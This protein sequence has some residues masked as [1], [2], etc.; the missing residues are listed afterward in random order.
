MHDT[1]SRETIKIIESKNK[2]QTV[3]R[4]RGKEYNIWLIQKQAS[5]KGEVGKHRK[6]GVIKKKKKRKKSS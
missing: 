6:L 5:K 3:I 2:I 4:V 1:M